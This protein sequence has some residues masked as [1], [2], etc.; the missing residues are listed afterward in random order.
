MAAFDAFTK[1]RMEKILKNY[2]DAKIPEHLKDEYK[3]IYKFRGKH[4]YSPTRSSIIY[5]RATR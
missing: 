1:K 4:S 2:I 3:I 5:A